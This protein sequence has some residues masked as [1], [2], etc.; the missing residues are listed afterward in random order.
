VRCLLGYPSLQ[1]FSNP[2]LH[3]LLVCLDDAAVVSGF[4][5]CGCTTRG[6]EAALR[7][8][9]PAGGYPAIARNDDAERYQWPSVARRR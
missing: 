4:G 3:T 1:S 2:Y 6:A 7:G 8:Q 9:R 5:Q